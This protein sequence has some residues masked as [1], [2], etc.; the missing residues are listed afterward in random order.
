MSQ[1][2]SKKGD[3]YSDSKKSDDYGSKKSDDYSDS[4]KGDDYSDGKQDGGYK[5]NT[6]PFKKPPQFYFGK[7]GMG[8]FGEGKSAKGG[9]DYARIAA[10]AGVTYNQEG[11]DRC[12]CGRDGES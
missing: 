7:Y 4:K 10:A 2:D 11:Y 5:K 6:D 1:Y 12:V 9:S 8:H 3:D